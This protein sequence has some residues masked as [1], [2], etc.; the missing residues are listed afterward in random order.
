MDKENIMLKTA[1][2]LLTPLIV[3]SNLWAIDGEDCTRAYSSKT[4]PRALFALADLSIIRLSENGLTYVSPEGITSGPTK[5]YLTF[6]LMTHKEGSNGIVNLS[7][8]WEMP[9]HEMLRRIEQYHE[10]VF[11]EYGVLKEER[12]ANKS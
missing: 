7:I 9:Q 11:A 3:L 10:V 2:R 4:Y 1:K 12:K 6:T 8:H 5:R